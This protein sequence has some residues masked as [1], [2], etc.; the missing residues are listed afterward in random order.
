MERI[1]EKKPQD[2]IFNVGN[3]SRN[4]TPQ[5]FPYKITNP[6]DVNGLIPKYFDDNSTVCILYRCVK[7]KVP[8]KTSEAILTPTANGYRIEPL[9]DNV[10][11]NGERINCVKELSLGD[12]VNLKD[13]GFQI[14]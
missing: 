5:V 13:I 10:F 11:I 1:I 3:T 4:I 14:L 9:S 6:R 7:H 2:K 8:I 12:F